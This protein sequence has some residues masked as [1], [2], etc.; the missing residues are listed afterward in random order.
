[1]VLRR[2]ERSRRLIAGSNRA[3]AGLRTAVF[4]PSRRLLDGLG[5]ELRELDYAVVSLPDE[6][7]QE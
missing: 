7:V 1:M 3:H 2:S 4:H 5:D 6:E